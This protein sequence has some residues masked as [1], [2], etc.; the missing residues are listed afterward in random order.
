MSKF[1]I[2][3]ICATLIFSLTATS[4]FAQLAVVTTKVL[5]MSPRDWGFHI[6]IETAS[7]TILTGQGV[8]CGINN[9]PVFL[10]TKPDYKST[11]D[12]LML[13]YSMRK[14]IRI[15]VDKSPGAT[16]CLSS[17]FPI[18]YAIDVLEN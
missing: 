1:Q 16:V 13:A 14:T 10:L 12:A 4:A 9:A 2:L 17:N 8:T 18:I 7:A 15:Y 5:E 3:K 6:T 11:R